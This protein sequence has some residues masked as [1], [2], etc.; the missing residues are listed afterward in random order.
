MK[1]GLVAIE[2]DIY[3]HAEVLIY[4]LGGADIIDFVGSNDPGLATAPGDPEYPFTEELD[5][6]LEDMRAAM[7]ETLELSIGRG[8]RTLVVTYFS[9][10]PGVTPC[11]ALG[12]NK[13]DRT[14]ALR[15]N[16]YVELLDE[17]IADL[18]G[19]L[20][21]SVVDLRLAD[22]ALA[23][24]LGNFADCTHPSESGAAIVAGQFAEVLR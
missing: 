1:N 10:P 22:D 14:E 16:E 3:P 4:F 23:Q 21:L 15:V 17:L 2:F 7:S 18:A 8:Y 13:L 6:L 12:G 24:D 20:Q 5:G 11:D 19:E 9:L